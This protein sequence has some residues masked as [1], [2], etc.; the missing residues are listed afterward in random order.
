MA[1]TNAIEGAP[2][3][4]QRKR[5]VLKPRSEEAAKKLEQE[6]QAHL[7]KANPFGA[8][9]PREAVIA[10]KLGKTEEEVLKEEV[11]KEKL[12][13]RLSGAQLEEKR[14]AESD[15]KEIEE[16][17]ALEA[18]GSAKH[19]EL[20]SELKDRQKKLDELMETF[21]KVTLETALSGGAPRVSQIRQQQQLTQQQS[22]DMGYGAA[23]S[24]FP[25]RSSFG[26][27]EFNEAPQ[28]GRGAGAGGPPAA[29]QPR[30]FRNYQ[31]RGG[32]SDSYQE[33]QGGGSFG[34]GRRGGGGGQRLPEWALDD[35]SDAG[36]YDAPAATS[37]FIASG[38]YQGGGG[39]GGFGGGRGG[40]GGGGG[41]GGGRR[42]GGRSYGN[43]GY[44]D[45]Y[46]AGQGLGGEFEYKEEP[47]SFGAGQDRF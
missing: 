21:A 33:R 47:S 5:L 37:A 25:P 45:G 30:G 35:S 36:F 31:Q 46:P 28:G 3:Q 1:D 41:G 19:A 15:I 7:T 22:G 14:Q 43:G 23:P 17:L 27:R 4:P 44:G 13:L 24:S 2:A 12:H 20:T 6:R 42:G 26:G 32:F 38:G 11:S 18:E 39:G 40:R 10:E 29:D 8:A 34:G 9:K 16:V